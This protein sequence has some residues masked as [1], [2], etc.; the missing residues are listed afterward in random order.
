[1]ATKPSP[2]M[3]QHL[4]THLSWRR[5]WTR[6]LLYPFFR[7]HPHPIFFVGNQKSGTTA[8]SRLFAIHTG[9]SC[10]T[11]LPGFSQQLLQQIQDKKIPLR[12]AI[13]HYGKIEFSRSVIKECNLT[14]FLDELHELYPHAPTVFIVRDP[15]DNIRSIL[16]YLEIP[17]NLD[18]LLPMFIPKS[19]E[20]Q[21]I[22]DNSWLHLP[23]ENYI[24]SLASRWAY[25][26]S[27]YLKAPDKYLL[28]RYED[29][30][31]NKTTTIDTLGA[32]LA[33]G[34]SHPIRS[35]LEYPFQP[36]SAYRANWIDFFG[37][38]NLQHIESI[39]AEGIHAFGY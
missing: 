6:S 39:C 2:G 28:L 24:T 23:A 3:N 36:R 25:T 20:W 12:D 4:F 29:F 17:G 10:A 37:S 27:F 9:K 5:P 14:L 35:W 22:L 33:P 15:R 31:K 1:M 21:H 18:D 34:T 13:W 8:I 30:L 32:L 19:S 16:N 11:W 26:T 38:K 7:L